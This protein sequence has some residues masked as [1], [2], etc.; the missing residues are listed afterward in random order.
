MITNYLMRP[1]LESVCWDDVENLH[2]PYELNEVVEQD[3]IELSGCFLSRKLLSYCNPVT[4][5]IFEDEISF[6]CFVNSIHIEDYVN[7][8]YFQYSIVFCNSI[9]KKW[10]SNHLDYL[11]VIISLDDETLLP[12]IKFHLKRKD[13]SWLD[14]DKLDSSIQAV[15]ITTHGINRN[16][17]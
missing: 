8:K 1:Q 6:E 5:D 16:T 17:L 4:P 10:N 12:T 9:I 14:E 2:L 15:L 7:E 3:F 13:V 11:N